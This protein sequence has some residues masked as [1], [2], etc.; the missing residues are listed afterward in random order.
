MHTITMPALRRTITLLLMRI[1]RLPC[2]T[3]VILCI[4]RAPRWSCGL[5]SCLRSRCHRVLSLSR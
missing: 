4:R 3:S 1:M 5:S 2:R